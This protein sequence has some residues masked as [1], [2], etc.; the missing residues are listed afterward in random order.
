LYET[1][2]GNEGGKALAESKVLSNLETLVLIHNDITE[3]VQELIR[4]SKNLPKLSKLTFRP[5]PTEEA[6]SLG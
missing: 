5:A 3:D 2:I 1:E 4:N 6:G